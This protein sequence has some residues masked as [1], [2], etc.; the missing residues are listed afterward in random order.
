MVA[1]LTV[2]VDGVSM[3]PTL[4]NGDHLLLDRTFALGPPARGDV[5]LIA[6]SNGV[7]AVKRVVGLPGDALEIDGSGAHSIVLVRP[8]GHGPWMRLDERYGVWRAPDFCCDAQGRD[9]G[10]AATPITLPPDEFYLMG[11]NRDVSIDSRRF[12]PVPRERILARV[13]LRY[14]PVTRAGSPVS[15]PTLTPVPSTS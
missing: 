9:G 13:W 2:R 12:G 6:E 10:R 7:P 15:A 14:W 5:V 1:F 11:D 4:Q 8:G 3:A